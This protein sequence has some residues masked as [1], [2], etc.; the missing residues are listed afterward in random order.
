MPETPSTFATDRALIANRLATLA[1][2]GDARKADAYAE[3]F[4][5][6]GVLAL[7]GQTISGREAIR[8]WMRAP[9]VIPQ[10]APADAPETRPGH[11]SHH[12][13]TMRIDITGPSTA[14]AR[15]YWFV[16]SPVGPDHSGYYDDRLERV[17]GQ[18]LVAHRRPRTLWV[19]PDSLIRASSGR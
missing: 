4:T 12:L 8:A 2:A 17:D 16:I 19:A 5:A 14:S 1:Q 3:C 9:S 10:P 18:W 6:A 15:T 7:D 13:T 11:V